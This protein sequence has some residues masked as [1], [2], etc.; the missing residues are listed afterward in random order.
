ME[1][2]SIDAY[3]RQWFAPEDEILK[4]VKERIRQAGMPQISIQP[5]EGR[6]LQ[7]LV[8][9]TQARLVLE[10]GTLGGYSGIYLARALDEQGK[11]VTLEQSEQHAAVAQESF[12]QAGVAQRVELILGDAHKTLPALRQRAPFDLIFIDADKPG[13]PQYL[14]WSLEL[15]KVGGVVAVHNALRHGSVLGVS[16]ADAHTEMMIAFNQSFALEKRILPTLCPLGD[17]MLVGV[18]LY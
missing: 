8:K 6:F 14:A 5:E 9:A 11:L 15:L 10:I 1:K 4:R 17:G 2:E 13:Y 12:L 3:V 7:F 16:P 18:K